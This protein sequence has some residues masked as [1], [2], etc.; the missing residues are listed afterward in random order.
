MREKRG[1]LFSGRLIV[2]AI[3]SQGSAMKNRHVVVFLAAL[4]LASC[5]PQPGDSTVDGSRLKELERQNKELG[6]QLANV[7][8]VDVESVKLLNDIADKLAEM[9]GKEAEVR[10]L[11]GDL[12][13]NS[14]AV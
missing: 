13:P 5:G 8:K 1:R 6:D 3:G 2:R 7:S 4:L 11:E 14:W 12:D 10:K 9:G